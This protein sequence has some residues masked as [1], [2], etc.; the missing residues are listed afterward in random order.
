MGV[1]GRVRTTVWA[2]A[3]GTVLA[4][5]PV[6]AYAEESAPQPPAYR[7]A[8]GARKVE[9]KPSTADAPLIEAGNTYEDTIGPGERVYRLVLQ[10]DGSNAYVSAVLRPPAG[11]RVS[12]SDGVE[13]ELMTT[14]GRSCRAST[15]RATFGYDAVPL[16]AAGVRWGAEDDECA[17]AGVYYAKV[18]RT[19]A[20]SSDQSPWPLEL[21]VQREP[22]RGPGAPTTAPSGWP[23]GAP[24][25]PGTEAV[26]RAGGTGF[27][28][29]RALGAG[30]WRDE[31]R[32]GQT[33]WYRVPLDWGQRLGLGAELSAAKRTKDFTSASG[34]LSVTLYTPFRSPVSGKGVSY[35][36]VQAGVTLEKTPPVDY[37][38]R[39]SGDRET[40]PVSVAGWYY[41]AVTM[42]A[43]VADFTEDAVPVPLTLRVEVTGTPAK[44]PAYKE[45]PAAGGFG[46]GAEDRAAARE[47]LTAPEAAEA[48]GTRSLMRVVAGAGF[49]AGT[50]LL[51]VLGGWVLLGRRGRG[52]TA[53]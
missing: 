30:V 21:K 41:V 4:G 25:L 28:D 37:G 32:P 10:Q 11:A 36:G 9:G 39:F 5:V 40:Q 8:D 51:A 7:A 19:S 14:A 35:D 27:N 22:G 20:K 13:V 17:P 18:T 1:V 33:R 12:G 52:T 48:A 6:A 31:M 26:G 44:G 49:G 29:A 23:T 24:S 15:G 34:G 53:A 46:V 45:D 2:A 3:L 50:L 16:A 42:G 38:N 43:K 47:G